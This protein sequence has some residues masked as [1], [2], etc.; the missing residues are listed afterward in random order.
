MTQPGILTTGV[1]A[2]TVTGTAGGIA[3]GGLVIQ[4]RLSATL[5]SLIDLTPEL[6]LLIERIP[7]SCTGIKGIPVPLTV[8]LGIPD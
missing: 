6:I 4:T 1:P 5:I 3:C 2:L 8:T 7:E